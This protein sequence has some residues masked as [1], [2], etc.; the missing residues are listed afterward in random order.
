MLLEHT[1]ASMFVDEGRRGAHASVHV[2][3]VDGDFTLP[4]VT[5]FFDLSGIFDSRTENRRHSI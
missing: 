5:R 4:Y 3:F 1:D 2:S